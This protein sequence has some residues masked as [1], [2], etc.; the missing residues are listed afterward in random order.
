MLVMKIK[1]GASLVAY[2]DGEFERIRKMGHMVTG[3]IT[4][5]RTRK[6]L[7]EG[8][9]VIQGQSVKSEETINRFMGALIIE[10]GVNIDRLEVVHGKS[11]TLPKAEN[12]FLKLKGV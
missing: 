7:S 11:P 10:D 2:L 1:D 5:T 4:G 6:I 3:I 12:P 9:Q 8:C